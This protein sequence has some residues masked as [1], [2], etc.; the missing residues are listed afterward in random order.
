MAVYKF[1]PV[2]ALDVRN[3]GILEPDFEGP[4]VVGNGP[5]DYVCPKCDTI[6]AKSVT[7][8]DLIQLQNAAIRC[9]ECGQVSYL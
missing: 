9:N 4:V 6:I 3:R 1:K 7:L 8:S 2:V 5:D